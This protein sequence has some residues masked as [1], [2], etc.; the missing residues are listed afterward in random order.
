MYYLRAASPKMKMDV[1]DLFSSTKN[2]NMMYLIAIP[3]LCVAVA[4][5]I[6]YT[7]KPKC[8]MSTEEPTKFNTW[9]LVAYGVA[10]PFFVALLLVAIVQ[11]YQ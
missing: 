5:T 4:M 9:K 7:K 2:P 6:I 8:C 3:L 11:M 10:I 1:G